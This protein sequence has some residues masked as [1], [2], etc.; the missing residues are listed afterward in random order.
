[1]EEVTKQLVSTM[2]QIEQFSQML[3]QFIVAVKPGKTAQNESVTVPRF[4]SY[5]K[6]YK[7]WTQ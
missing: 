5:K 1:M 6:N 7:S 3:G 2:Q 4:N